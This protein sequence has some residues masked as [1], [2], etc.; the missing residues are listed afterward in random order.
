MLR[1]LGSVGRVAAAILASLVV[2][3]AIVAAAA[4]QRSAIWAIVPSLG[5][6]G[7]GIARRRGRPVRDAFTAGCIAALHLPLWV[8]MVACWNIAPRELPLLAAASALVHVVSLRL[9]TR[10]WNAMALVLPLAAAALV[11]IALPPE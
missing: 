10:R 2:P 4:W 1:G 6:F 5:A 7:L 11:V 3:A 9:L 8:G